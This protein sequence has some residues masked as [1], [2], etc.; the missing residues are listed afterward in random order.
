MR[1]RQKIGNVFTKNRKIDLLRFFKY[2]LCLLWGIYCVALLLTTSTT[3]AQCGQVWRRL[4]GTSTP[5]LVLRGTFRHLTMPFAASC[6][7]VPGHLGSLGQKQTILRAHH[8]IDLHMSMPNFLFFF[9]PSHPF[10]HQPPRPEP[11][12]ARGELGQPWLPN[13][14]SL[15]DGKSRA[16]V[17]GQGSAPG[18][19]QRAPGGHSVDGRMK[20]A[21]KSEPLKAGPARG[22]ETSQVPRYLPLRRH[23][24]RHQPL[25]TYFLQGIIM[26]C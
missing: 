14:R 10:P 17:P 9:L 6:R 8:F 18:T 15:G 19:Y 24:H 12:D 11:S 3:Y 22:G 5:T 23:Q 20:N 7:Y 2:W 26:Y 25:L 16:G 21:L 13:R 1:G 4:Q